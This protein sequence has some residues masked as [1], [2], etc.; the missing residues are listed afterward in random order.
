MWWFMTKPSLIELQKIVKTYQLGGISSQVLKAV[1]LTINE[2]E[3]VSIVGAS[4]S[5]KSTLMNII[6]LLDKGTEGNYL[7]QGRNIVGFSDDHLATLRNKTIGF[8]FQQFNLLPRFSAKQNVALPLIYRNASP[9]EIKE[10]V[11]QAL[12]RVGMDSYAEHRPS[13]LSG[14]QQQRVAI[15]RALVGEPRVILADEPTGALDSYTGMEVMKLFRNLHQEGRTI[16]MVTH[17]EQ[18]AAQCFR[19]ITLADGQIVAEN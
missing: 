15:A 7:L 16:I 4:G 8:V 2:G 11:H 19:R 14:G 13:Q 9:S 18:I 10:R 5:G 17:D 3:F 12:A 1:S 6:G